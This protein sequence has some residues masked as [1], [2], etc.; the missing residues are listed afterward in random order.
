[1]ISIRAEIA[2]IEAGEQSRVDNPLKRSPHTA[3]VVCADSWDRSY[4]RQQAAFPLPWVAAAKFW[5]AVGRIDNA[6]GDRHLVCT[7][8]PLDSYESEQ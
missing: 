8:P 2:A 6:Y 3:A 7:C 1:M 5:P 4:T